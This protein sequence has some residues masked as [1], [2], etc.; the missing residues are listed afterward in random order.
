VVPA[1]NNTSL[2]TE[3]G[4]LFPYTSTIP[5]HTYNEFSD[6][7]TPA[8]KLFTAN[9]DGSHL[10][11]IKL[12]KITYTKKSKTVSFTFNDGTQ[13]FVGI[14]DINLSPSTTSGVYTLNGVRLNVT[15]EAIST[16]PRGIYIIK[17]SDG[18]TRKV[19]Q[20]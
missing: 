19:M 9:S 10:L 15:P 13:P 7:T 17:Q 18:S 11:H 2:D 14:H 20:K 8:D 1:D 5:I 6:E 12:S 16:L 3:N 4:D